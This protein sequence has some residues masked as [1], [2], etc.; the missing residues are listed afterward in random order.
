MN[1]DFM[2]NRAFILCDIDNNL[3]SLLQR[4]TTFLHLR[5]DHTSHTQESTLTKLT[6]GDDELKG[7]KEKDSGISSNGTAT[8]RG[9]GQLIFY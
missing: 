9:R 3:F 7:E 4:F 5:F 8:T 1:L 6:M 2:A